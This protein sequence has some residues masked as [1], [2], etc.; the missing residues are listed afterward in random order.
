MSIF[1]KK[2]SAV[3]ANKKRVTFAEEP[4][5]SVTT[6]SYDEEL[7][8]SAVVEER[9]TAAKKAKKS[10]GV[11]KRP[12][13]VFIEDAAQ[14]SDLLRKPTEPAT[15]VLQPVRGAEDAS[16]SVSAN[17]VFSIDTYQM[18]QRYMVQAMLRSADFQQSG[19]DRDAQNVKAALVHAQQRQLGVNPAAYTNYMIRLVDTDRARTST[20]DGIALLDSTP[21]SDSTVSAFA[22]NFIATAIE[23]APDVNAHEHVP[24]N[25]MR[26]A[27]KSVLLDYMMT[28]MRTAHPGD[29]A[30]ASRDECVGMELYDDH[31]NKLPPTVWK[32]C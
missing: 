6:V 25:E 7:R 24:S 16:E 2:A 1:T 18:T 15:A 22:S 32:V 17:N 27:S 28:F 13:D 12:R 9:A 10:S 5:T 31:N 19:S 26:A 23:C 11:S 4:Q 29:F 3:A 20:A 30:C 8:S 21:Y 14:T